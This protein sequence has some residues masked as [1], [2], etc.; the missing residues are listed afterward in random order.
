MA[1]KKQKKYI[2]VDVYTMAKKRIKHVINSFDTVLVAFSGGKDSLAVLELV[3]E[4][5]KEMGIQE[6]VKVIFRDEELIP[7][8]VIEFVKEHAESGR[9][10]FRYYAIP[11]WSTKFILGKSYDYI[12]WDKDREWLRQPPEYAITIPDDDYKVYSQYDA[13]EFIAKNEKGRVA[14]INGIRAD[15]SLTRLMS[16]VVKRN[17]NYINSTGSKRIKL[18]KPIYDWTERDLF[19]YFC[20]NDIR[21]CDIYDKQI[22][23]GQQLRV[24]TPLHAENAK[25][26]YKLKTL[27]PKFYDQLMNLFPEMEVQVR[28]WKEYDRNGVIYKYEHSFDGIRDYIREHISDPKQQALALKRV[29]TTERTRKNKLKAGQG[30]HNYGGYPVLHV[31]KTILAGQYKREIMPKNKLTQIDIDYENGGK[32]NEV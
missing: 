32:S 15:E 21:Y 9:W 2:D 11:L 27:Y 17:E 30:T 19:V 5:Y 10:D 22:L 23:N 1:G 24:A 18:V 13:D 12:Q 14:F 29:N 8:D 31:F 28:Y 7:D 6:K 4:V 16:C 20:K 3:D 25:T 26:L